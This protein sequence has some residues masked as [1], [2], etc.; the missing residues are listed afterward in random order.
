MRQLYK[1]K[2]LGLTAEILRMLLL[3]DPATGIFYWRSGGPGRRPDRI[4]GQK[5]PKGVRITLPGYDNFGFLAHRLAW[6][7]MTGEWPKVQVDHKNRKPCENWWENLRE[8]TNSQNQANR[9]M[10]PHNKSGVTGVLKGKQG[11]YAEC[12][13]GGVRVLQ[14]WFKTKKA[15]VAARQAAVEKHHAEFGVKQ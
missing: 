14:Q 9:G 8:A 5:T 7:Y 10:R 13:I 12:S 11:W 3:Y 4:A 1:D 15:A 2:T 6:L